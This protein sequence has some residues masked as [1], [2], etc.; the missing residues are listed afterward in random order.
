MIQKCYSES[1]QY[2][3][4]PKFWPDY[5]IR[6][7]FMRTPLLKKKQERNKLNT[8]WVVITT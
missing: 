1:T 8:T 3:D 5:T 6:Y 4:I 7:V 2:G